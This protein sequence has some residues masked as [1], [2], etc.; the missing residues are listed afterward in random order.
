MT[1]EAEFRWCM[2]A[3]G[4]PLPS[5]VADDGA[6]MLRQLGDLKDAWENAGGDIDMTLGALA[7]LGAEIG[8]DATMLAE[9]GA[10]SVA[11]YVGAYTG[12]VIA[13][14]G[15][16]IWEWITAANVSEDT[17]AMVAAQAAAA[18]YPPPDGGEAVVAEAEEVIAEPAAGEEL[19]DEGLE[20][21]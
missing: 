1:F 15:N 5:E 19:A 20:P 6:E 10:L 21:V 13:A 17:A 8:I 3:A 14:G 9:A 18:G 12:C 11:A 4:V 7:A 16:S 2:T